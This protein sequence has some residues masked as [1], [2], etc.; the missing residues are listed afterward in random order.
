MI[1]SGT[2]Q[3]LKRR[4]VFEIAA[5]WPDQIKGDQRYADDGTAHG[6]RPDGAPSSQNTGYTDLLRHRYWHFVDTP[7]APDGTAVPAIPNPNAKERITLFRAVLASNQPDELKSYDLSEGERPMTLED[8][9]QA[10]RLNVF[11]R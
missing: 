7:F 9:V 2:P 8:S 1:P 5:T 11:R 4:D 10:Q 3:R 6:N